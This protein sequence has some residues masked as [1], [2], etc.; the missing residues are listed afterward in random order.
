MHCK[1]YIGSKYCIATD[2]SVTFLIVIW[3]EIHV[4]EL[5]RALQI[6]VYLDQTNVFFPTMNPK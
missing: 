1:Y 6:Q 2:C 4:L 5:K 3:L